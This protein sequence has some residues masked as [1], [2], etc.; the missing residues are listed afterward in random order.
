MT[1]FAVEGAVSASAETTD[2]LLHP[3]SL[4]ILGEIF[5]QDPRLPL[6]TRLQTEALAPVLASWLTEPYRDDPV[7][8]RQAER[9]AALFADALRGLSEEEIV[10]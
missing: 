3:N 6:L 5:D 9:S 2:E 4:R 10:S 8:L 7:R 1:E